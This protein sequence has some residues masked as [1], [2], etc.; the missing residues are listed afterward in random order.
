MRPRAAESPRGD[1]SGWALRGSELG[2][3]IAAHHGDT[4]VTR[5]LW[6]FPAAP[7]PQPQPLLLPGGTGGR[8][9]HRLPQEPVTE[10]AAVP[11]LP[12]EGTQ[13]N[14]AVTLR[15]EGSPPR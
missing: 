13:T 11:D 14:L 6:R 2:E 15:R 12:M 4:D 10:E 8:C 3:V 5:Q 7:A 1:S 9:Q